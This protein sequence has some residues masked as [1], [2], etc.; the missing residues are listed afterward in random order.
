MYSVYWL[1]LVSMSRYHSRRCVVDTAVSP[2]H[3]SR[4][5]SLLRHSFLHAHTYM[6]ESC[7][8]SDLARQNCRRLD[9]VIADVVAS[10][11]PSTAMYAC[12]HP[13]SASQRRP[14]QHRGE[15]M[16][17]GIPQSEG[18]GLMTGLPCCDHARLGDFLRFARAVRHAAQGEA[19]PMSSLEPMSLYY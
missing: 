6:Q 5:P 18:I 1:L 17:F 19:L 10:V 13:Y 16:C 15:L 11:H 2:S 4:Q 8:C 3:H 9:T 14:A 12:G 7:A